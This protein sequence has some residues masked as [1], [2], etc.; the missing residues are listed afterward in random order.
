MIRPAEWKQR[1]AVSVGAL[2]EAFR[3][4]ITKETILAYEFGLDDLEAE[5]IELAVRHGIKSCKFMPT[6]A[7]LRELANVGELSPAVR[8]ERAWLVYC[9]AVVEVGPYK[10]VNFDDPVLNATVRAICRWSECD[11][12]PRDSYMHREFCQVYSALCRSG[13]SDA[14]AAPLPGIHA[15]NNAGSQGCGLT[16]TERQAIG[17]AAVTVETGLPPLRPVIP[18]PRR[19]QCAIQHALPSAKDAFELANTIGRMP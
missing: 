14:E 11:E 9:K 4:K 15:A 17:I 6:P 12:R 16:L 13:V 2:G 18:G 8:A 7:E 19:G 10:T 5:Q 1:L 3:Q